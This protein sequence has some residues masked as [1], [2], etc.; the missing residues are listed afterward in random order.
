M[1]QHIRLANNDFTEDAKFAIIEKIEN[2]KLHEI[3]RILEMH[4]DKWIL[5]LKV[6]TPHGLNNK[7]NHPERLNGLSL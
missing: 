5:R 1:E 6:M 3:T 4:E 2:S 7:L